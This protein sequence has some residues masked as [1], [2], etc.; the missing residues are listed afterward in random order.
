M[1]KYTNYENFTTYNSATGEYEVKDVGYDNNQVAIGDR[2]EGI[3]KVTSISADDATNQIWSDSAS[4]YELTGKFQY[5]VSDVK[6]TPI[7]DPNDPNTKWNVYIDFTM[8]NDDFFELYVDDTKDWDMNDTTYDLSKS[9]ASD[10]DLWMST[11]SADFVKGY[12]ESYTQSTGIYYQNLT[13]NNSGYEIIPM[14]W[15][16]TT[17]LP[18]PGQPSE[19]TDLYFESDVYELA[20]DSENSWFQYISNDPMYLYATPEPASM[21]LFGLGLLGLTGILRKKMNSWKS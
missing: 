19:E 8:E 4:S 12:N 13:V 10:G 21:V 6:Y 20:K 18:G 1:I 17:H 9:H 15:P 5:T 16:D 2:L 14:I 7:G 3:L 11:E